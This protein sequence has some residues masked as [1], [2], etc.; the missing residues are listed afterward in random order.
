MKICDSCGDEYPDSKVMPATNEETF[1]ILCATCVMKQ[2]HS[3][4]V[5]DDMD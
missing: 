5:M 3:K 1:I 4:E 2:S